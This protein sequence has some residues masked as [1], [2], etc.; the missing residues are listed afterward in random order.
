[1]V[2]ALKL[3]ALILYFY[4]AKVDLLAIFDVYSL[5]FWFFISLLSF[6][7]PAH[8]KQSILQFISFGYSKHV[9][10]KSKVLSSTVI[11]AVLLTSLILLT[12]LATA[13]V[14]ISIDGLLISLL[15]IFYSALYLYFTKLPEKSNV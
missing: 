6:F 12:V 3:V 2:L 9:C 8:P 13:D 15:P 7:E 5:L 14:N 1:M 4:I 10:S 11:A